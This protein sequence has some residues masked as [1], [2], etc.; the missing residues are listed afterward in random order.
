MFEQR[1]HSYPARGIHH[2]I[3]TVPVSAQVPNGDVTSANV[4]APITIKA[5]PLEER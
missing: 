3:V 5:M 2:S 4:I 1:E